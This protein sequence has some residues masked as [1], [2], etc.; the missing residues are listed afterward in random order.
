MTDPLFL[1]LNRQH[2]FTGRNIQ[3]GLFRFH[4]SDVPSSC[5]ILVQY[6]VFNLEILSFSF[7]FLTKSFCGAI[8][9]G[10]FLLQNTQK[11]VFC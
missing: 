6:Y 2:A 8:N 1:E 11:S 7:F 3:C 5:V 10:V 9:I 4:T